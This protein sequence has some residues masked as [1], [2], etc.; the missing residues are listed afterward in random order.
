[1]GVFTT[2]D[3][4]KRVRAVKSLWN[5]MGSGIAMGIMV[6]NEVNILES[7]LKYHNYWGVEKFYV[8]DNG[9]TDGT[10]ELIND[11]LLRKYDLTLYRDHGIDYNQS[12]NMTFLA[13]QAR[14]DGFKWFIPNDADEF[15]LPVYFEK[16]KLKEQ[17]ISRVVRV[18]NVS[19]ST[20][21]K[22][23]GFQ[24]IGSKMK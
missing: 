11:V 17:A 19:V 9:S 24:V 6:K 20:E 21:E 5:G 1:M 2:S 23:F 4:T 15:W 16:Y 10:Y 12:E 18:N 14:T 7:N 22:K 3:I 8:I 13:H